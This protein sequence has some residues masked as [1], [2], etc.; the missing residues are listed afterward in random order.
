MVPQCSSSSTSARE[1][2]QSHKTSS[3]KP[4]EAVPSLKIAS[5][6]RKSKKVENTVQIDAISGSLY[7][8]DDTGCVTCKPCKKTFTSFQGFRH[9]Y[10][11][12]PIHTMQSEIREAVPDIS[13]ALTVPAVTPPPPSAPKISSATSTANS[14]VRC[15]KCNFIFPHEQ[16]LHGHRS[17]NPKYHPFYCRVCRQDYPNADDYSA[18]R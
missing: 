11:Q 14:I 16:S 12:A 18:V 8:T 17:G 2:E 9:H 3:P 4:S 10:L 6:R 15:H 13:P 5:G 7:E 1:S